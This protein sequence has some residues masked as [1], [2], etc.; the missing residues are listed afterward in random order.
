MIFVKVPRYI[1]ISTDSKPQA[2][3]IIKVSLK[4][5]NQTIYLITYILVFGKYTSGFDYS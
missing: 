3:H 2:L 5:L 1:I 4:F